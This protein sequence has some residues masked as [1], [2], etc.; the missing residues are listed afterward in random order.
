MTERERTKE[1][2]QRGR[3]RIDKEK[4]QRQKRLVERPVTETA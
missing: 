1:N 2:V 3:K 4:R